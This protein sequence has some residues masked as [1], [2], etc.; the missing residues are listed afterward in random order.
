MAEEVAEEEAKTV[1]RPLSVAYIER[2]ELGRPER[3]IRSVLC[4]VKVDHVDYVPFFH[5]SR[6]T[7]AYTQLAL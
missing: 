4:F 1:L 3:N 2:E 7:Y 5:I 6:I